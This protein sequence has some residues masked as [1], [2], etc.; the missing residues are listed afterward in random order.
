MAD[1]F[2]GLDLGKRS[3]HSALA[4][5]YR[6]RRIGKNGFV[7]RNPKG[8]PLYRY[9]CSKLH[10]WV[11][12]TDYTDVIDDIEAKMESDL[13]P[14]PTRL[15]IDGTGVGGGVVEMFAN[16]G[17]PKLQIIPIMIT[18]GSTWSR[19]NVCRGLNGYNVAKYLLAST[20][21]AVFQGRHIRINKD[22][23][24]AKLL[25]KE[26][27]DFQVKL[28]PAGNQQ[29]EHRDGQH[30]DI[31]LAL[32]GTLWVGNL[33]HID[34]LNNARIGQSIRETAILESEQK[35]EDE[36]AKKEAAARAKK[37]QEEWMNPG[38]NALWEGAEHD[39]DD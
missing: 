6:G 9:H 23:P 36:A 35:A 33:R 1:L 31:V 11:K 20:M 19:V 4:D 29:F 10:R 5:V 26:L 34:Y 16:R 28:T 27:M 30:D 21:Q 13:Y 24:N 37:E 38:N 7:E 18:P 2:L 39:D 25:T 14:N 8:D 32:A 15:V 17:I 22:D 12:G 3:D